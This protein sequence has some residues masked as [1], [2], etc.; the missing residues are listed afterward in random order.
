MTQGDDKKGDRQSGDEQTFETAVQMRCRCGGDMMVGYTDGGPEDGE[1]TVLHSLP[2][3]ENFGN[4]NM[5]Q[6]L[7]WVRTGEMPN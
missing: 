6:Y 2:Q 5:L 1:P 4:L 3:C 7:R